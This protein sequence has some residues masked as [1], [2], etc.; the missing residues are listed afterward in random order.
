VKMVTTFTFLPEQVEA[1]RAK[2][3]DVLQYNS[4]QALIDG[5]EYVD[6][7]IIIANHRTLQRDF[8]ER[9]KRVRWVQVAHIGIERLPMDYLQER[10][11]IVINARGGMG[12]PI[13]EDILCKMLMLSR[14]SASLMKHQ[15]ERAWT[16]ASGIV[17]LSGKT[18]GIIGAGDVGTETAIRARAFGM[19]T[20][21]INTDGRPSPDFDAIYKPEQLNEVLAQSDF[22]VLALPLTDRTVNL[23]DEEQFAA[24]RLSSFLINIS[25]G[26]LINEAALLDAL[27][28]RRIAGA[29]LDVFVEEFKLGYLPKESPFWDLDNI[30]ITPHCAGAGDGFAARFTKVFLTNLDHFLQ[31]DVDRMVNVR[32]F[33]KGY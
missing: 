20:I 11:V 7:D 32:E 9:C 26:A 17:N 13:A 22:H 31:G 1:M 19:R 12:V 6:A 3:V 14:K 25:R 15:F 10:G 28:N 27:R 23:I 29:A 30:I 16:K 5:E 8:L 2:G 33:G 18:V 4:E 24:M 21:G